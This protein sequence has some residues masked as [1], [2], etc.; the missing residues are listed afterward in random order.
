MKTILLT[1]A[2]APV[3]LDL[4][5]ALHAQGHRVIAAESMAYPLSI[6][7]NAFA[8]FYRIAAPND[9][10]E[11]FKKHLIHIIEREKVDLLIPTCEEAF[12]LSRIREELS[13]HTQVFVDQIDKLEELHSKFHFNALATPLNFQ[14]PKSYRVTSVIEAQRAIDQLSGNKVVLKPEFSRFAA[15]TLIL[16]KTE[17]LKILSDLSLNQGVAWIVQQ[18][19]EGPEYCTYSV[20]I[21]GKLISHVTYDHEFTAG[22]GAGICFQAINHPA[23]ESWVRAFVQKTQFHGQ[24]A[25]DFIETSPGVV[26]PLECNPRATSGL[27][28]VAHEAGFVERLL[29]LVEEN[30]TTVIRPEPGTTGQLRLAMLV[31]G[32]ASIN[33]PKRAWHW[34]KVFFTA[35]EVVFSL[36]DPLPFLDQFVTFFALVYQAKR[37]KIT[38]LEV[39]TR[40]IEWNGK[41]VEP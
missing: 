10:L 11:E 3:T 36:R 23:I 26:L 30:E 17:A 22:R 31:Y 18:C 33:S 29:S 7:S 4:A 41:Q 2:R 1:G 6:H 5:R 16:D 19:L 38:A 12:H 14:A 15:K 8:K 20:A 28:L 21:H 27:H 34:L 9:S 37:R 40:D 24:L 13:V 35:R 32:L 25:F 39:S